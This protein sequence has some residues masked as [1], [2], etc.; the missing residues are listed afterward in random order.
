MAVNK[1][2]DLKRQKSC[3]K[4]HFLQSFKMIISYKEAFQSCHALLG[5]IRKMSTFCH[6]FTQHINAMCIHGLWKSF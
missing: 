2:L 3:I 5:S 6:I 4:Q 1:A